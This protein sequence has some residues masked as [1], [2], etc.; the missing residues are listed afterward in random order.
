MDL[1]RGCGGA[2]ISCVEEPAVGGR[3]GDAVESGGDAPRRRPEVA[4]LG[5]IVP[6]AG[7]PPR[8]P[9]PVLRFTDPG[10]APDGAFV[11]TAIA[12]GR[13]RT[14]LLPPRDASWEQVEEF[15]LTY[16]GYAYWSHVA[17]L[18]GRSLQQ[19][20]RTGTLPDD[21]DELRACLFFEE[22]RWHHF[23][24]E[25]HGRAA[26]YVASLLAAITSAVEDAESVLEVAVAAG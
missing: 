7:T 19:W 10:R 16:D 2:D 17:E 3:R 25:P 8:R 14:D 18:A 20:T 9:D 6:F 13:L 24:E 5:R 11:S 12:N 22:R 4:Q 26:R 23:G 21:L 1:N 15:A